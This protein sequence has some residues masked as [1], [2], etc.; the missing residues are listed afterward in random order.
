MVLIG[1]SYREEQRVRIRA[2]L[3]RT[4]P[5]ARLTERGYDYPYEN[6]A[7]AAGIRRKLGRWA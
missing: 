5:A 7:I 2:H 3:R 1:G 4:V 6:G